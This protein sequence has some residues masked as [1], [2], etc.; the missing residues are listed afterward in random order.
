M[1]KPIINFPSE[2]MLQR[3]LAGLLSRMPGVTGVQILQGS[4]ELGKDLVFF[5]PGGFGEQIL[6]ACI[7]K[8]SR[9]SGTVGRRESAPTLLQQAQQ[10]FN[11]PHTDGT[12]KDIKVERVYIVTPFDLS[13]AT[14]TSVRG[15]LRERAGQI[16]FIGGAAL[17][18]LFKKYWPSFIADEATMMQ[19]HLKSIRREL[20]EDFS[21][22]NVATHFDLGFIS[23]T[24]QAFYV[25]QTFY[26]E[27][28][29][30]SLGDTLLAPFRSNDIAVNEPTVETFTNR[31]ETVTL[32]VWALSAFINQLVKAERALEFLADW[33]EVVSNGTAAR[34]NMR[35]LLSKIIN[36][37]KLQLDSHLYP[38]GKRDGDLTSSEDLEI[39]LHLDQSRNR[40]DTSIRVNNTALRK[41]FC[42]LKEQQELVLLELQSALE[43]LQSVLMTVHIEGLRLLSDSSFRKAANIDN[44]ARAAPQGLF[45]LSSTN[46]LRVE[47]PTSLLDDWQGHLM[48]VGAPGFG[49]TSFCRWYA[50][51]DTER[52]STGQTDVIPAYVPLHQLSKRALTSFTEMFL[53]NLGQSALL[54]GETLDLAEMRIR[55]YL[56]GLDEVASIDRRRELITIVRQAV[57]NN[58]KYQVILTA[59]EHIYGSWLEW[60]P[61]VA[62]GEFNDEDISN[63]VSNWL[64]SRS[65]DSKE[66]FSQL[67][68]ATPLE[69][70]M[71][72]P[73]LA[74]LII[75]LFRRTGRL[76]KNKTRLYE[77]WV[78]L[79][80]GRWEVAKGIMKESKFE[81]KRKLEFLT[82]LASKVH[83][84][85]HSI[86]SVSDFEIA[87]KE[88]LSNS[89]QGNLEQMRTE[90]LEDGLISRSG[91]DFHFPHLSLQEFLTA[92]DIFM[93][94]HSIK[95]DALLAD[96][97][98]GDD[99]WREVLM[100]YIGLMR[101]PKK[102]LGWLLFEMDRYSGKI[103]EMRIMSVLRGFSEAYSEFSISELVGFIPKSLHTN[104]LTALLKQCHLEIH[105]GGHPKP[106]M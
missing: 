66:F 63:L 33:D 97:L 8:N 15:S 11:S 96:Y 34:Q 32:K 55:L 37:L 58:R 64:G 30:I 18:D 3:A 20:R 68:N 10:A 106:A 39:P 100:F 35:G 41:E 2:A 61:R 102:T 42:A 69:T 36:E 16:V 9:I 91:D 38:D 12:G 57:A 85:R 27:L 65:Y 101:R 53:P 74:T 31:P 17:F 103:N 70:L 44:C 50:L 62:L 14:I 19:E 23:V 98:F 40:I 77:T 71:R 1:H 21:L 28:C 56:D 75:L 47:F 7:V 99:W 49:K 87:F 89:S 45:S 67:H 52:F 83:Q 54:T 95:A 43:L 4:L 48:I 78:E 5:L 76:P 26:R 22:G 13:P 105:L 25:P 81:Q 46:S 88:T 86:F 51:R 73:L 60:L 93:D 82:T 90:L 79:L 84:G 104:R 94:P 59:R 29:R 24:P 72:T 6:C 80:S 92:S